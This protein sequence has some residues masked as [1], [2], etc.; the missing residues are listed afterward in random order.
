MVIPAGMQYSPKKLNPPVVPRKF[1]C[2][3][4]S[5]RTGL[6]NFF[7]ADHFSAKKWSKMYLYACNFI[8]CT[9]KKMWDRTNRPEHSK[10]KE[11]FLRFTQIVKRFSARSVEKHAMKTKGIFLSLCAHRILSLSDTTLRGIF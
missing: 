6:F 10:S 7:S 8:F 4:V 5:Q 11:A 2:D 9:L 1:G 3:L